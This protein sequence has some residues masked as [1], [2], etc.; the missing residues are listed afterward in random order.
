M[1]RR[2][3][4]VLLAA[5]TTYAASPVLVTRDVYLMGTRAHLVVE[6]DARPD[7]LAQLEAT[8]RALEDTERE[9]STWR[10][11]SAISLLN[12]HPLGKPWQAGPRTCAMLA[13]VFAWSAASDGT[14][15]PTVQVELEEFTDVV[16]RHF[17]QPVEG[18]GFDQSPSAHMW[19]TINWPTRY[20]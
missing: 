17:K 12:R 6:A 18:L 20:L 19:R 10:A 15:D 16:G 13:D 4:A 11:D 8:L 5:T 3:A 9:L 14:F 1:I 7:G 2:A